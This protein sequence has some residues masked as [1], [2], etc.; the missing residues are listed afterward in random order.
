MRTLAAFIAANLGHSLDRDRMY[1]AQ[2]MD[3]AE[4]YVAEVLGRPP[5]T[6]NAIDVWRHGR[7]SGYELVPN[8]PT[9]YPA[10]G[11]IVV[12]G[13]PDAAVG[14]GPFG[15]IAV[16]VLADGTDL[17]SF[18]QNWPEGSPCHLQMHTYRAVLGW[19]VASP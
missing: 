12:W 18:D 4:A 6:G 13:G 10:A 15:H 17:L 7:R 8:G 19:L 14:T 2:C 5:L 1:G 11:S 9:N 16:A 3:L